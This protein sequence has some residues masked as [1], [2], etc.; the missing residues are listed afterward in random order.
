MHAVVV[1]ESMFGNTRQIAEAIGQGLSEGATTEVVEVGHAPSQVDGGI[2]LLVVGGPTHA[3]SMS[4]SS[5]RRDAGTKTGQPIES[6]GIGI[7]EWIEAL[8]SATRAGMPLVATFDTKVAK[9]V[10][11]S[12]A[13]AAMKRLEKKGYRPAS[14]PMTF[15]VDDMTGPLL[16]GELDRARAWGRV[17]AADA[18]A[19][20]SL[21]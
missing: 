19:H 18:R 8:A 5:T 15:K 16:D 13:K 4:R 12:A 9:P 21:G 17:V 7:R 2:D 20:A 11:G 10:P 3:F 6:T 14:A 1:Y